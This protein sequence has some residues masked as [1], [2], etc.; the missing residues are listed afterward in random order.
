MS[1]SGFAHF[2]SK[3]TDSVEKRWLSAEPTSPEELEKSYAPLNVIISTHAIK[4][5]IKIF[6]SKNTNIFLVMYQIR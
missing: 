6:F 1:V 5:Q 2:Y 3:H 4:M